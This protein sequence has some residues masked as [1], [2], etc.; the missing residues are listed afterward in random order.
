M[1]TTLVVVRIRTKIYETM[2]MSWNR[3]LSCYCKQNIEFC[4]YVFVCSFVFIEK[5]LIETMIVNIPEV[6][7]LISSKF[8]FELSNLNSYCTV[9][10]SGGGHENTILPLDRCKST[11]LKFSLLTYALSIISLLQLN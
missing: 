10:L 7:H 8:K 9:V 6:S 11:I 3:I 1:V 5:S 4:M 2:N